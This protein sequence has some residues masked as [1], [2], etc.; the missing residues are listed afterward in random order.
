M[1]EKFVRL[2][3]AAPSGGYLFTEESVK[4]QRALA[5]QFLKK[6]GLNLFDIKDVIRTSLPVQLFEPI[7]YLQRLVEGFSWMPNMLLKAAQTTNPVERLKLVITGVI[8]GLHL[9]CRQEK[10]F[11]PILGETFQ[12]SF[13]NGTEVF[14]E[15]VSHH[16]P[17]SAWEFVGPNGAFHFSGRGAWVASFRGNSVKGQQQGNSQITFADGSTIFFGPLPEVWISG[18][19]MGDRRMEYLGKTVFAYPQ[20][21]L[22]CEVAFNPDS[23]LLK[24]MR[25]KS[26][27]TDMLRGELVQE[28]GPGRAAKVATLEGS[29]MGCVDFDGVRAW[30]ARE[31][32]QAQRELPVPVGEDRALPSDCRF[33]EDLQYL[34]QRDLEKASE[35]KSTLE[36][37]Q[38]HDARL[39]KDAGKGHAH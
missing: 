39:R 20:Y 27:P 34:A 18:I 4:H 17:V 9:T 16:P 10:P 11:N 13:S 19:L 28:S 12:A 7:S 32:G 24:W 23:G 6:I 1:A 3:E 8:A 29:W 37:R 35:W 21:G 15:Q 14:C 33:R 26:T 5:M 25:G 36:E 22:T 38:R 30:D 31:M 2:A